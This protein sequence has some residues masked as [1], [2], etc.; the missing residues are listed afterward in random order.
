MSSE[1]ETLPLQSAA[2]SDVQKRLEAIEQAQRSLLTSQDDKSGAQRRANLMILISAGV[3]LAISFGV[4]YHFRE[5]TA[6]S[7]LSIL[8]GVGLANMALDFFV[9]K[10][11]PFWSVSA[12]VFAMILGV[13]A[14]VIQ[15]AN[16]PSDALTVKMVTQV[17]TLIRN[18]VAAAMQPSLQAQPAAQAGGMSKA[19]TAPLPSPP[20]KPTP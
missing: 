10:D 1:F 16:P 13:G 15:H 5:D 17:D 18:H 12:R 4:S 19:S 9:G 2:I 20:S 7:L 3:A 8:V 14:V 11:K 6:Y